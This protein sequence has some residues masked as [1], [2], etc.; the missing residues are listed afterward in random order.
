MKLQIRTRQLVLAAL[1]CTVI[2]IPLTASA[3]LLY[4]PVATVIGD[5]TDPLSSAGF[6]VSVSVYA[7]SLAGQISPLSSASY[8]SGASGTRL[9]DSGSAHPTAR[10][11]TTQASPTRRPSG[12]PTLA[13]RMPTAPATTPN[14]SPPESSRPARGRVAGTVTLTGGYA[15]NPTTLLSSTSQYTANNFRGVVGTDDLTTLYGAGTG[16]P[17]SSAG[18]RDFT[19]NAILSGSLTNTRTVELLGGYLFGS[20]DSTTN[21]GISVIDPVAKTATPWIITGASSSKSSS[22]EFAL[23]DDP[24]NA[25]SSYGYN[26]AYIADFGDQLAAAGGIE[27]W[28]YNGTAWTEPYIL[29]AAAGVYYRG[30]A[31][32]LD[33][34]TGLVTLFASDSTGKKLQQVTDTGSGS[35]FTT[36]ADLTGTNYVFRGVALAPVPEPSTFALLAVGTMGLL[37]YAWRRR[38]GA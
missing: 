30:L 6:T 25:N 28:T 20:S 10:L 18:F 27:K 23:F 21:V 16:T 35:A 11:P 7:N 2:A 15:T 12:Y 24:T 29:Q 1:A 17:A 9:V 5:G 32:E 37:A 38:K 34:S 14:S 33:A 26:V 8:N 31:G 3:E 22:Y 4:N 36:L 19:N 13:R